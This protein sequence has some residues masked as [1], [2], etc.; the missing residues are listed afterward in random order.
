MRPAPRLTQDPVVIVL[1]GR[2]S[3]LKKIASFGII[4]SFAMSSD[5]AQVILTGL[6]TIGLVNI[7][8][9]DTSLRGN[10]VGDR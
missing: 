2:K 1:N 9:C 5:G 8:I 10:E 4:Q 6:R 3:V 7:F